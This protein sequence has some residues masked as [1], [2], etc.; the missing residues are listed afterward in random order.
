MTQE[1]QVI[2]TLEVDVDLQPVEDIKKFF[3]TELEYNIISIEVKEE[4]DIYKNE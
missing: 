3:L 2:L 1:I 4:K